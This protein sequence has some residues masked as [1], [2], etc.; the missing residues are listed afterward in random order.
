MAAHSELFGKRT[1]TFPKLPGYAAKP[2]SSGNATPVINAAWASR[3]KGPLPLP[4]PDN[5]SDRLDA[6]PAPTAG[7]IV[8]RNRSVMS[9]SMTAG[10]MA[11]TRTPLA[12]N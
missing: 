11:L 3:D 1:A 6:S 5:Q 10:Q 2:P 7:L 9:V 4:L 12:A 8:W